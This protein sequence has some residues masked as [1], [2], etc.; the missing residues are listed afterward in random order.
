M[1]S[2]TSYNRLMK[3]GKGKFTWPDGSVYTGE[4]KKD[5]AHG[6]GK[7]VFD[8][9]KVYSGTWKKNTMCGQGILL[10]NNLDNKKYVG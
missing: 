5:Y 1:T 9:K 2:L 10:F 8:D 6:Q 3:H 4:F 7:C